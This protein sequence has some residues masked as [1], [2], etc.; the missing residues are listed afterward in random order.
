[1]GSLTTKDVDVDY[2]DVRTWDSVIE[3]FERMLNA[4]IYYSY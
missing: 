1:M 2:K 3:R 4:S